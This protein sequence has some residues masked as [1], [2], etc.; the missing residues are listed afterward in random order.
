MDMDGT[1]LNDEKKISEENIKAIRKA[2]SKGVRVAVCTGRLFTSA[3]YYADLIGT[4]VPVIAANG[5]YIREKDEN[6]II[7]KAPLSVDKCR[8]ILKIVKDFD[9]YPHFNTPEIVLTEK[10]IYS[11]QGYIEANKTL[12]AD[13][14][15]KIEVV[16]DFEE[17]FKKYDGDVLKCIISDED[18]EKVIKAKKEMILD[19]GLEVVS[20]MK[21]NFEVMSA[22]ASKGKAVEILADFYGIKREEIICFGDSENDLSMIEYAGMGIAMGNGED[23][24]KKAAKYITDTNNNDGIAKAIEKFV[25]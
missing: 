15:I 18:M 13:S 17:A 2:R 24:V 11:S 23:Y 22:G 7:Y 4:K 12:P 6:R 8:R 9:M 19:G 5:A 3:N 10:I 25:F 21:N 1:L 14:Q 20:S 16:P